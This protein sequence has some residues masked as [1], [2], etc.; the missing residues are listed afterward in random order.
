MRPMARRRSVWNLALLCLAACAGAAPR[1]TPSLPGGG[2]GMITVLPG[3]GRLDARRV[4]PGVSRYAWVIERGGQVQPV[5]SVTDSI[6]AT[7]D[8]GHPALARTLTAQR[9]NSLLVDSS[10]SL[11][12]SL[13][14]R[15][16]R[17][18]QP[19]RTMVLAFDGARV[20]GSVSPT[21]GE[22]VTFDSTLATPVFDSSNWD[23]L[24]R[25][26]P[27]RE[28]LEARFPVYDHDNGGLVWY[29]ARVTGV[30]RPDAGPESWRVEGQTGPVRSTLWVDR[31]THDLVKVEAEVQ[32][33][34]FVR[35]IRR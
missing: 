12:R 31:Q 9:G 35:Q 17:S 19:R 30:E 13:V 23:L 8:R 21:Q 14:P 4:R 22:T 34:V 25:S 1:S 11:A 3:D 32:P 33:G 26:L 6:T 29:T 5:G 2:I 16:H 15:S 7:R 20:R 18:H 10:V 28:G 24:V 27:L